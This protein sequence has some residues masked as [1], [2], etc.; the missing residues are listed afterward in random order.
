MCGVV[1]LN[2][3]LL[4][5]LQHTEYPREELP[6]QLKQCI[7]APLPS[8]R[9]PRMA[10]CQE[11]KKIYHLFEIVLQRCALSSVV[12]ETI[13]PFW[14][15]VSH[16]WTT[17]PAEVRFL[18]LFVSSPRLHFPTSNFFFYIVSQLLPLHCITSKRSSLF[19]SLDIKLF[20]L[21]TLSSLSSLFR[22]KWLPMS[23]FRPSLL[24]IPS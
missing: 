20:A 6:W 11:K 21:H 17:G 1:V 3:Y 23:L 13:S 14:K 15:Q 9:T 24:K 19:L 10:Y 2:W 8:V 12:K 18:H 22:H 7:P 4:L 16:S 5:W